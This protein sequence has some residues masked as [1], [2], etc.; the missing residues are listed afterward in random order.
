MEGKQMKIHFEMLI[1]DGEQYYRGK[2]P[3]IA[4]CDYTYMRGQD[5]V[6][7]SSSWEEQIEHY[8]KH[9]TLTLNLI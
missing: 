4:I 2:D 1:D 8:E 7:G 9:M 6:D 5:S 3:G